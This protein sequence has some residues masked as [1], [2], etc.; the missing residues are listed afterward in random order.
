MTPIGSER[1][2]R[3]AVETAAV[4]HEHH[5][6]ACSLNRGC[7]AF[8]LGGHDA[9]SVHRNLRPD[10]IRRVSG[11]NPAESPLTNRCYYKRWHQ[12]FEHVSGFVHDTRP[13]EV[14]FE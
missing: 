13:E 5:L 2:C 6:D 11:P 12:L 7:E 3:G 14:R 1:V 4:G 8:E 10:P 9:H